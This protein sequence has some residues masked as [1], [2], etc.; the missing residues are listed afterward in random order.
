[1]FVIDTHLYD[2]LFFDDSIEFSCQ[3]KAKVFAKD[4]IIL[5]KLVYNCQFEFEINWDNWYWLSFDG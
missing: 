4:H 1:M 5:A 3:I 2:E